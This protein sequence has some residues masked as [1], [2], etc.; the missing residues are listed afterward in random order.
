MAAWPAVDLDATYLVTVGGR[1]GVVSSQSEKWRA[2][3]LLQCAIA[4]VLGEGFVIADGADVL[5]TTGRAE[6]VALVN[7]LAG[8]GIHTIAFAT[9]GLGD[10]P[11]T[12]RTV[13]V[14][15]GADAAGREGAS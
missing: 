14:V 9:G 1:P 7:H 11:P 15:A 13:E 12:W 6:F 10:V 2:Q 4:R 8:L 5:D 3:F